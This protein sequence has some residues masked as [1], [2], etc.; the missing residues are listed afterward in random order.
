M[1]VKNN[2][3]KVKNLDKKGKALSRTTLS[4]IG[5]PR[6]VEQTL[7][8]M[9]ITANMEFIEKELK[10]LM[11]KDKCDHIFRDVNLENNDELSKLTTEVN[12]FLIY[13]YN[14]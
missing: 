8:Q 9:N 5:A 1:Q 2:K 11:N 13:K 10:F 6:T 3:Q 4:F 7:E 12:G 14:K